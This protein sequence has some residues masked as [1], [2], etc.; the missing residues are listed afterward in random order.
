MSAL[1]SPA[2]E[3]SCDHMCSIETRDACSPRVEGRQPLAEGA[4]QRRIAT[5]WFWWWDWWCGS[6]GWWGCLGGR[7]GPA[8]GLEVPSCCPRCSE[9]LPGRVNNLGLQGPSCV[10]RVN[11][12]RGWRGDDHSLRTPD[13]VN[14]EGS[15]PTSRCGYSEDCFCSRAW[16]ILKPRGEAGPASPLVCSTKMVGWAAGCLCF[17]R[18]LLLKA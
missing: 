5:G 14:S 10:V 4:R 9:P 2:P 7:D 1:C 8:C 6:G 13:A 12:R 15:Q 3:G 11:L 18:T 16:V 17:T